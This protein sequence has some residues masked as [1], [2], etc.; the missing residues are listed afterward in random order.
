MATRAEIRRT[1]LAERQKKANRNYGRSSTKVITA[2]ERSANLWRDAKRARSYIDRSPKWRKTRAAGVTIAAGYRVTKGTVKLT[3]KTLK[4]TGKAVAGGARVTKKA[5]SGYRHRVH[6]KVAGLASRG[7]E[8]AFTSNTVDAARQRALRAYARS[9]IVR[10]RVAGQMHD[11]AQQHLAT[12]PRLAKAED[13]LSKTVAVRRRGRGV[14]TCAG[15]GHRFRTVKHAASHHCGAAERAENAAIRRATTQIAG[16]QKTPTTARSAQN[17]KPAETSATKQGGAAA[18]ATNSTASNGKGQI[19]MVGW[20][21]ESASDFIDTFLAYTRQSVRETTALDEL[22]SYMD[23]E[24]TVDQKVVAAV[25]AVKTLEEARSK[26][27]KEIVKKFERLYADQ[28][29]SNS[30]ARAVSQPDFFTK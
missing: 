26:A 6:P 17:S 11:R 3:G 7:A 18:M 23:L 4:V 14:G 9:R 13:T 27:L 30:S 22:A 10:R 28:L 19:S 21:P 20:R 15:C 2:A 29:N 16:T 8:R 25:E 24:L 5:G 1:V 12:R